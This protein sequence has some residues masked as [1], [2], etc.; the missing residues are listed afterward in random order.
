MK[1]AAL[2]TKDGGCTN[3][4]ANFV[5]FT[6]ALMP[7]EVKSNVTAEDFSPCDYIGQIQEA[8]NYT[9]NA[10]SGVSFANLV[11]VPVALQDKLQGIFGS[12]VQITGEWLLEQF[13]SPSVF[14][15]LKFIGNFFTDNSNS[16]GNFP[17]TTGT[18]SRRRLITNTHNRHRL[19]GGASPIRKSEAM[20]RGGVMRAVR[21]KM[22][23]H[24]THKGRHLQEDEEEEKPLFALPLLDGMLTLTFDFNFGGGQKQLMFGVEFSFDSDDAAAGSIEEL[25]KTFLDE[26][27]G[28]DANDDLGGFSFSDA[29][30]DLAQGKM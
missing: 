8:L 17:N 2:L 23:P 30:T 25:L 4:S 12:G 7:S 14:K 9:N 18:S 11:T 19:K 28:N 3:P 26:T 13:S 27:V 6:Y 29:A 5:E 10:K 15:L 21:N 24:D 1:H 20:K 22:A 16:P